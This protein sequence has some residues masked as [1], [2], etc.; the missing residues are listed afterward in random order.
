MSDLRRVR[1]HL[2]G[3]PWDGETREVELAS[4]EGKNAAGQYRLD[5]DR[6]DDYPLRYVWHPHRPRGGSR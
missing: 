4:L 1:V 6:T 3:G 2:V 5:P